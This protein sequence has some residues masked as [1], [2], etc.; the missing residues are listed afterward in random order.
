MKRIQI[1][2]PEDGLLPV[3]QIG[4]FYGMYRFF[5]SWNKVFHFNSKRDHG[6]FVA[7]TNQFFTRSMYKAR[8]IYLD[9]LNKFHRD[10]GYF[11][12]DKPTMGPEYDLERRCEAALHGVHTAFNLMHSRSH[13]DN[14]SS[15]VV[16]QMNVVTVGIRESIALLR[17][18]NI[19]RNSTMELYVL[20]KLSDDILLLEHCI[21]CFGPEEAKTLQK[22]T[23]HK[24]VLPVSTLAILSKEQVA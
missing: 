17:E 5:L 19:K 21:E 6:R 11:E 9:V 12:H 16:K 18:L 8:L 15:I 1:T 20:D 24:P 3:G 23:I 2:P 4:E 7:I 14:G 13:W 22:P 10:W